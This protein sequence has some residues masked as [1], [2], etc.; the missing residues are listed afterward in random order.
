MPLSPEQREEFCRKI[1]H[2]RRI[3]GCIVV[4]CEGDV[5]YIEVHTPQQMRKL[6][7]LPDANFWRAAIPQWWRNKK[8]V[9]IPCGDRNSVLQTFRRLKEIHEQD[10]ENSYLS[11]EKLFALADLDI[12]SADLSEISQHFQNTEELYHKMYEGFIVNQ[13]VITDEHII[14]TGWIHKEAYFLE[15]DLQSLF[16]SSDYQ[17]TFYGDKLQLDEIYKEMAANI[18][19]EGDIRNHYAVVQTRIKKLMEWKTGS[20]LQLAELYMDEF[21]NTANNY[22]EKRKLTESLFTIKKAKPCWRKI[23]ISHTWQ[24]S[25]EES[26]RDALVLEI[27]RFWSEKCKAEQDGESVFYHMPQWFQILWKTET[28]L[29]K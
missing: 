24:E 17:L 7:S 12:Q 18:P 19:E 23:S 5:A 28:Q 6:E 14:L 2:L 10:R 20:P 21:G 25:S 26:L 15:P 29:Q 1:L 11:P 3:K 4:L 13:K 9:F 27:G 8:P 16:D 22:A